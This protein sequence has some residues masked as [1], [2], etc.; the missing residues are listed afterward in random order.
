VRVGIDEPDYH[1]QCW[2]SDGY[3]DYVPHF[4]DGMA[5]MPETAPR[6]SDH[7]LQSSS[8]VQQITYNPLHIQYRTFDAKAADILRLT[9]APMSVECDGKPLPEVPDPSHESG[10]SFDPQPGLMHVHHDSHSVEVRG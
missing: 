7:L 10:W 9:F 6:A 3:F 4:L 1:N 2:F 8:V 5:C